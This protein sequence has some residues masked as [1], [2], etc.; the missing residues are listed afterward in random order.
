MGKKKRVVIAIVAARYAAAVLRPFSSCSWSV[1][2]SLLPHGECMVV[3]ALLFFHEVGGP[4]PFL[5]DR[6]IPKGNLIV[7]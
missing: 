6:P 5:H 4:S 2:S 1:S 7:I 3:G